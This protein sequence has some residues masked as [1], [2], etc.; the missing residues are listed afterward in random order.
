MK[1]SFLLG[2]TLS[3]I[4]ICGSFTDL[5]AQDTTK[6]ADLSLNSQYKD[7][8]SKSRTLDGYKLVNPTRLTNLWRS[9]TDSLKQE[10]RKLAQVQTKFKTLTTSVEGLKKNLATN[11]E[12]LAASTSK[13]DQVSFLGMPVDKSTYNMIMWGA[14]LVLGIALLVSIF[15]SIGARKEARYRIK[16]FEELSAEFQTYKVK[17]NER[18]KK[19][20]RELQDERNKLDDLGRRD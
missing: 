17:A 14:V 3:S 15:Q 12:A 8:L 16:L 9:A 2:L 18:E 7:M 10:H 11:E 1:N 6:V 4:L 20:A 19:L 13:L 5:K